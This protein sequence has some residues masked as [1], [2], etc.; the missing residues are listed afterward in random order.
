[1]SPKV[2]LLVEKGQRS[3]EKKKSLVKKKRSALRQTSPSQERAKRKKLCIRKRRGGST[4][5][6]LRNGSFRER[7]NIDTQIIKNV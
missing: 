5:P 3:K 7:E 1:V 2:H 6:S 4:D